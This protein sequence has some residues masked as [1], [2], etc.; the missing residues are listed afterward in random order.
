MVSKILFT[1][2]VIVAV[3][4][5]FRTRPR[6]PEAPNR[7]VQRQKGSNPWVGVLA[8]GAVAMMLAGAALVLYLDWREAREVVQIRVIDVRS[9]NLTSYEAYKGEIDERS[10]RT[11][12]GRRV[13]L[14]ET[15]RM[16]SGAVGARDP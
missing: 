2:A 7:L 10:F 1:I 14:A 8:I 13:N 12:D 4:F 6:P 11:I 3:L 9:G 5:F 15:E 16:E